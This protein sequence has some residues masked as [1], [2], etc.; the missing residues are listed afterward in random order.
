MLRGG[1]ISAVVSAAVVSATP[2]A[3]QFGGGS[4]SAMAGYYSVN[5]GFTDRYFSSLMGDVRLAPQFSLNGELTYL[6]R[7][8]NTGGIGIG[9]TFDAAQYFSVR[10]GFYTSTN[11]DVLPDYKFYL[12]ADYRSDP[13]VGIVFSPTVSYAHYRDSA[14]QVLID[15][16]AVKY[17]AL[18]GGTGRYIAVQANLKGAFTNPGG[19]FAPHG[20]LGASYGQM[21]RYSFGLYVEGGKASYD[22]TIGV[23]QNIDYNFIAVRPRGSINLTER[24]ELIGMLEYSNSKVYDSVGGWLGL[25]YAFPAPARWSADRGGPQPSVA[26]EGGSDGDRDRRNPP[27]S[28]Q[29]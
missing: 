4:I 21:G 23:G 11:G 22:S 29:F 18:G 20:G 28:S 3:A 6:D 14:E 26:T 27:A 24:I 17:F 7:E 9:G 10:G 13:S 16:Q 12:G 1:L 19:N 2:A 15:L 25:R 5:K 8:Q